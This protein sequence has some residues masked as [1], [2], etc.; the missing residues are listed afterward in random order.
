MQQQP[1]VDAVNASV[2][3]SESQPINPH[4]PNIYHQPN[5]SSGP[6]SSW[7]NQNQWPPQQDVKSGMAT[8]N[9]HLGSPSSALSSHPHNTP[10]HSSYGPSPTN[11]FSSPASNY[12]GSTNSFNNRPSPYPLPPHHMK[13]TNAGAMQQHHQQQNMQQYQQVNF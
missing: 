2:L 10:H 8:A 6:N 11:T 7:P 9:M 5:M 1:I 12:S 13:Y 4:Q 3:L